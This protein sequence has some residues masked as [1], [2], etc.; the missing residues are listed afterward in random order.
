MIL[1]HYDT[2]CSTD[3]HQQRDKNRC[4]SNAAFFPQKSA[5]ITVHSLSRNWNKKKHSIEINIFHRLYNSFKY[6][7]IIV[8]R[9]KH[10]FFKFITYDS[11]FHQI[12]SICKHDKLMSTIFCCVLRFLSL[13]I[14][15]R[16]SHR[17]MNIHDMFV[18]LCVYVFLWPNGL[19]QYAY[20]VLI[21]IM[22]PLI[23]SSTWEL[24]SRHTIILLLIKE[25]VCCNYHNLEFSVYLPIDSRLYSI[26]GW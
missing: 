1:H 19:T 23:T 11:I 7:S 2:Q 12:L 13:M 10:L 14:Q 26:P 15:N 5:K 18:V 4:F 25:E 3:V 17:N 20:R 16:S 9:M 6:F 24:E 22:F 8:L 21:D